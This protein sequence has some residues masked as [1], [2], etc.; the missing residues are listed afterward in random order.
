MRFIFPFTDFLWI[1]QKEEYENSRYAFWL[2]RFFFRRG[3]VKSERLVYTARAKATLVTAVILWLGTFY[4]IASVLPSFLLIVLLFALWC[5]AIPLFVLVANALL[6]PF[7]HLA[8]RRLEA[9]ARAQVRAHA[10]M[11]VVAIAGS[12]GKTTSKH[13]LY[14]LIRYSKRTQM[15][16][17]TVNTTAGIAAW[18]KKHLA[19][20]TELL[21]V[22]MDAYHPGEIAAS[23]R[24]TPP[25]IAIVTNIGEQ[26]M[27][28]FKRPER[29]VRAIGEVVEGAKPGAHVVAD[30]Q[31]LTAL[32]PVRGDRSFVEVD[33]THL[34]YDGEEIPARALS[35]SNRENLARVL[36][37][38]ELLG[39][40]KA[41]VK[42]SVTHLELPKRRQQVGTILGYEGID[43]SYNISLSTARA[44]LAAGRAFADRV[45]KK[46]LVVAAGIPELGPEEQDGN[47]R[48]GE[49]LAQAADHVAVLGSMF[50]PDIL[51]GLKDAPHT[52]YA[53]YEDFLAARKDFPASEWVLLL[54]PTLPD[55]YY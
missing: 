43:D 53:R 6:V 26:H 15:I 48:L 20:S 46:L 25:D 49:A 10:P 50:A 19:P 41:F 16:P 34:R 44:G 22:E 18:L 37:A 35:S 39:I 47:V 32:A 52:R 28:R 42:D 36:F 24:M 12:F 4:V 21:I 54:E 17:G 1:L 14:E 51:R 40:P 13:F 27:A 3:F 11:K 55:L 30:A 38:A 5:L 2:Q 23:C 33:T 29:L 31:T 45:H 9:R 8:H 7:M